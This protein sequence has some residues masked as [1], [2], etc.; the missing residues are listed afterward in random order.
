MAISADS[1]LVARR[2]EALL[3]VLNVREEVG[4]EYAKPESTSESLSGPSGPTSRRR[5]PPSPG[6]PKLSAT[7]G[8]GTVEAP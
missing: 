6:P 8:A 7:C 2:S 5:S 3:H 4:V 1:I